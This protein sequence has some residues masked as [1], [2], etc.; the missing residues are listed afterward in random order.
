[1]SHSFIAVSHTFMRKWDIMGYTVDF[2]SVTLKAQKC[3]K[4]ETCRVIN[5]L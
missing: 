5:S 1:M 4:N 2:P 3:Q